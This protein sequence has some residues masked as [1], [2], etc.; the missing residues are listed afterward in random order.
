MW[1]LIGLAAGSVLHVHLT[2]SL[3]RSTAELADVFPSPPPPA[4][5]IVG[6]DAATPV[7]G[8][9]DQ[10]YLRRSYNT[11]VDR[12]FGDAVKWCSDRRL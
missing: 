2:R 5:L 4:P 11:A 9:S 12:V 8:A 3:W 6:A 10:L 1:T 7:L